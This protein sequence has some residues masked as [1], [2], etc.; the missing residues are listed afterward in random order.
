MKMA[1]LVG[2]RPEVTKIGPLLEYIKSKERINISIY[3]T[4]QQR[5]IVS[6]TVSDLDLFNGHMQTWLSGGPAAQYDPEWSD[7]AREELEKELLSQDFDYFLILGDTDS[8]RLGAEVAAEITIPTV[9]AEAGIRHT[10]DYGHLEPE[11]KNRRA[12]SKLADLHLAPFERQE[13]LLLDEGIDEESI[14]VVG[15]FSRLSLGILEDRIPN[16]IIESTD[17]RIALRELGFYEA[18]SAIPADISKFSL[19]TIHRPVCRE[20]QEHLAERLPRLARSTVPTPF[21][22]MKRPDDRWTE[23]YDQMSKESGLRLLPSLP[24]RPF[25]ILLR[26]AAAVITDSAGVQQESVL[27]DKEVI[28]IR[29]DLELYETHENV[30]LIYPEELFSNSYTTFANITIDGSKN[31]AV[32]NIDWKSE[33]QDIYQRLIELFSD[34]ETKE[35]HDG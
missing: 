32:P 33:A 15:D 3:F 17:V 4:G 35:I 12:I 13:Q 22:L 24:P 5:E 25:H 23:F 21:F 16:T 10:R 8:S 26:N 9:H 34:Y 30:R 28:A 27:L 14:A 20:N 7:K 19:G 29:Q 6:S 2:T 1:C 18:A 31:V 11:E